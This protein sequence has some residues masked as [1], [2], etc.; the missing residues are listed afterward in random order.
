MVERNMS[1]AVMRG[2]VAMCRKII[3]STVVITIDS[4][5]MLVPLS[6]A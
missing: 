4:I 5:R 6:P 2:I 3:S 1:N